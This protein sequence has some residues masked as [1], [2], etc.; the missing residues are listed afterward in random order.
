MQILR[1]DASLAERIGPRPYEVKLASS[2]EL[3]EGEGEADVGIA[4]DPAEAGCVG[5]LRGC[6]SPLVSRQPAQR[7]VGKDG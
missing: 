1:L 2:L 6:A 3:A 4:V 7:R 5:L